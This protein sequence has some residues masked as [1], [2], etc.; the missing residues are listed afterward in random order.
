[1]RKFFGVLIIVGLIFM[2][3][4]Q[5]QAQALIQCAMV[6]LD[7]KVTPESYVFYFAA[8]FIV[9]QGFTFPKNKEDFANSPYN[10]VMQ[11]AMQTKI[12]ELKRDKTSASIQVVDVRFHYLMKD[13]P[14][15]TTKPK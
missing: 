12:R 10:F 7:E 15:P 5:V 2:V 6:Q 11:E 1:M 3:S 4:G 13:L 8:H 14:V 9:P